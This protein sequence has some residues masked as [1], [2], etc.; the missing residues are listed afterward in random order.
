MIKNRLI[1]FLRYKGMSHSEL[2]RRLGVSPT[3]VGAMRKSL[4]EEKVKRLCEIFPD[5]NRD[6]LIYG[7]GEM[8]KTVNENEGAASI[9]EGYLVP[10]LP[11]E[12]FAGN[13]Q[14]WSQGVALSEC[15][16]IVSPVAGADYA[17]RINGDSMEPNFFNGSI[18]LIKK[19]NE[20]AFIPW[21]NPMVIDSANGVLVKC[22]YPVESSEEYIEAR[23][24]NPKYPPIKVPT[25]SIFGLYRVLTS[26]RQYTTL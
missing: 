19:I 2:S 11:V 7:E 20:R 3:Y 21:G 17:I 18:I 24:Y 10:L 25:E 1:Q 12:A 14:A 4:P 16:K 9:P 13:I 15:E 6:W 8:I 23:S 22:V 5:L 26:I